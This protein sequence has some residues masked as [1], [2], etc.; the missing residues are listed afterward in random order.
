MKSCLTLIVVL[1]TSSALFSAPPKKDPIEKGLLEAY[2]LYQKKNYGQTSDKLR[3]LLTLLEAKNEKRAG[4]VLPA[5]VKSWQGGDLTR[6]SLE[7][8]GGGLS[9]KRHYSFKKKHISVKLV[10]DSPLADKIMKLISNDALVQL[11]QRKT[12]TISGVRAVMD[13]EHK[14]QMVINDEIL[15][16]VT[17]N[18]ETTSQEI[19]TFTR[20]LDIDL[21]KKMK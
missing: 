4:V 15:L 13:G 11:S 7:A 20:S 1:A 18:S 16:E 2:Q 14:L 5:K 19:V 6:E 3:Q 21:M 9:V 12:H 10:K 17:G 8:L